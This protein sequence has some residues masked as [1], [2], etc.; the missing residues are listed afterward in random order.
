MDF[1]LKDRVAVVTGASKGIGRAIA[2]ALANEGVHLG[3]CS[4]EIKHLKSIACEA[5]R[6]GVSVIAL[7]TDVTNPSAIQSF[8]NRTAEHFGKVDILINNVGGAIRFADFFDL[9]EEEWHNSFKLNLMSIVH[10]T[11]YTFPFLCNSPA[12]RIINISSISGIE[13]GYYNPHYTIMKS[14]ALNLT[15]YLANKFA[16]Q[17]I[18]VNA[19]VPGPVYSDSW[20]R[21]IERLATLQELPVERIKQEV[22]VQEAAKIPLGR[23]GTSDDVASLVTFLTSDRASWITG[24]CFTIDGGKLRSI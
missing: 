12:P 16:S 17:N 13:P 11:R 3:L 10:F 24:A 15:K 2:L 9:E 5:E 14:A 6:A 21:N 20:D 1:G 7:S 18:L 4:R 22:E 19:V 8:V 23:V